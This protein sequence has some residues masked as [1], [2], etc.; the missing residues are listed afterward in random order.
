M[1]SS[2]YQVT[3]KSA[4]QKVDDYVTYCKPTWTVQQLKLHI[5]ETHV[6]KPNP[7]DQRLIYAGNLLKD[8]HTLKQ[9]FF[10]DS[11][12]TELTNASKTDFTIHLVC[13]ANLQKPPYTQQPRSSSSSSSGSTAPR[14]NPANSNSTNNSTVTSSTVASTPT[15][16]PSNNPSQQQTTQNNSNVIPNVESSINSNHQNNNNNSQQS[17]GTV[18]SI[19]GTMT[20]AQLIEMTRNLFQQ[21]GM[22][23]QMAIFQHMASMVAAQIATNIF[24]GTTGENYQTVNNDIPG[25]TTSIGTQTTS[26]NQ[27]GYANDTSTPSTRTAVS[28]TATAAT[29]TPSTTRT[30]AEASTS[31]SDPITATG[32]SSNHSEMTSQSTSTSPLSVPRTPV[33][34]NAFTNL[35]NVITNDV[36]QQVAAVTSQLLAASADQ[37]TQSQFAAA[38][39]AAAAAATGGSNGVASPV[40]IT[41]V[42]QP[43]QPPAA[44]A[45]LPGRDGQQNVGENGNRGQNNQLGGMENN[46]LDGQM[47]QV[48]GG[49]QVIGDQQAAALGAAEAPALQNDVIDWVYYSIRAVVLVAA[50]YIHASFFRLLFLFCLI[51]VVYLINR[52]SAHR[53]AAAAELDRQIGPDAQRA[54]NDDMGVPGPAVVDRLAAAADQGLAR[55]RHALG[56]DENDGEMDNQQQAA[57]IA[58][59]RGNTDINHQSAAD[60]LV[61]RPV[62]FLK[63]CYLVITNFLASLVP[64]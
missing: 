59:N 26:T 12:C 41:S 44:V 38:A 29:T 10:R 17:A 4:N 25:S 61:P 18:Y 35:H 1:N 32:D 63:L 24:S 43:Q 64:E 8:T 2:E 62:R 30:T 52:R 49:G 45:G 40:M 48:Q 20:E 47:N 51:G 6:N 7:K 33:A 46:Q 37:R 55:R 42:T 11:L 60:D 56:E 21:E 34:A 5:S 54:P 53:A 27:S 36:A 57:G 23:Q 13:S 50:L 3:I 9:I 16:T 31:T 14:M 15:T 19:P 22:R 39:A 58:Q 28:T